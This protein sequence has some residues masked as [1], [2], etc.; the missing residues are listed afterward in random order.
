EPVHIIV[1]ANG[2]TSV[3]GLRGMRVDLGTEGSGSRTTALQVLEAHGLREADVQ[4]SGLG[5]VAAGDALARGEID[6]FFTVI[7][8][9]ARH[10]QRLAADH[11][12]RMLPLAPEAIDTLSEDN[13]ALV[14]VTL[15]AG[16]YPGQNGSVR[17]VAVAALLVGTSNLPDA[18]VRRL[19]ENVY[20][21][22]DFIAGGS[23]AG[24]MISPRRARTGVTIPMPP[25]AD[26]YFDE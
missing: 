19:L 16:T 15:P 7:H 14:P 10:L 1:R 8:A 21:D 12:I 26:E 2:P 4:S 11:A 9:P 25:A 24:A 22:I 13:P 20:T 6:A 23:A 17:T 3:E 5:S 18:E